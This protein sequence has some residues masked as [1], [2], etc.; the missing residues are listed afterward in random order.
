M[1]RA[2]DAE[3][4]V[5]VAVAERVARD[6]A[7]QE[8][9]DREREQRDHEQRARDVR[10]PDRRAHAADVEEVA[11]EH[12]TEADHARPGH[13]DRAD[14]REIG[15]MRRNE[16]AHEENADDRAVD[17]EHARPGEPVAERRDRAG[18]REVPLPALLGVHREPARLVRE[19]RG[20]LR[21]D[22][23]LQR[24]DDRRSEPD[25][26]RPL[27]TEVVDRAGEA[28]EQ[29]A[30]T[31]KTHHEAV[32]PAHRLQ[33]PSVIDRYFCHTPIHLSNRSPAKSIVV[34][35]YSSSFPLS[36]AR[37]TP[38]ASPSPSAASAASRR[39]PSRVRP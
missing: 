24:T 11:R 27:G 37:I 39:R 35:R 33:E 2:I 12:A 13:V 1:A 38:S 32:P 3:R 15:E 34:R 19:H 30:R 23:R 5:D 14:V 25:D 21:V 8:R 6:V 31:R 29:E 36:R 16:T 10:E 22:V 28:G 7:V 4:G 17:R 18:Q 20:R 9:D 26:R